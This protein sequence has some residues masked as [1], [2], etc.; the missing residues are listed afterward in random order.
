[1]DDKTA[2]SFFTYYHNPQVIE[3]AKQAEST[4]DK[5]ERQQLYSQIQTQAANDAFMIFEFYSPYRYATS[6]KVQDFF[7]YPTGNYH[8]EDVW[9]KQ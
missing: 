3:W 6:D 7:V 8:M 9:L 1:V 5:T 4:F 2:D